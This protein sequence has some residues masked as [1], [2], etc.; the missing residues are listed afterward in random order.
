MSDEME[1]INPQ[2]GGKR[3]FVD[4]NNEVVNV[5]DCTFA[6]DHSEKSG[7]LNVDDKCTI[8]GK[9]LGDF[10]AEEFNPLQPRIPILIVPME[11]K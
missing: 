10:I 3:F 4:S 9:L 6:G 8:C 11:D 5:H 7:G 2:T 1:V